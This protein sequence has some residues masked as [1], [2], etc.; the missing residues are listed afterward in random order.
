MGWQTIIA[1]I[2]VAA[3]AIWLVRRISRIVTSG[4]R[5][6]EGHISSCGTCYKNPEAVDT[7]P[8]VKLGKNSKS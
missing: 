3:A 7:T 1:T 6:G 5:D 8:L 2:I 4:S